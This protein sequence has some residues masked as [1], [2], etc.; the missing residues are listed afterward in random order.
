[1]TGAALGDLEIDR[2]TL[3]I[4]LDGHDEGIY[5]VGG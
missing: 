4:F 5:L 2:P 3:K 1:M